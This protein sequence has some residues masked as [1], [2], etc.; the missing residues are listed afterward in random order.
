MRLRKRDDLGRIESRMGQDL[1]CF[2]GWETAGS[3]GAAKAQ[4]VRKPSFT[5]V[6]FGV[7][8]K[9]G[10]SA[11]WLRNLLHPR[12]SWPNPGFYRLL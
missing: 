12:P 7:R 1:L 10:Q 11:V 4:R 3:P 6:L 9:D 2:R 8:L 5:L